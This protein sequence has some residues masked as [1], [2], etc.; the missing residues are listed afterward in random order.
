MDTFS[1]SNRLG[2]EASPYLKR[3]AGQPVH[4]HAWGKEPFQEAGNAGRPLLVSLGY[5]ANQC[6]KADAFF[7]DPAVAEAA[8]TSFVCVKVD[9]FERPEVD[10]FL[11]GLAGAGPDAYPLIAFLTPEGHPYRFRPPVLGDSAADLGGSIEAAARL[12]SESAEE[13]RREASRI[14]EE[15]RRAEGAAPGEGAG[16]SLLQQAVFALQSAFDETNGGFG[17]PP[18]PLRAPAIEFLL[19]AAG[20]GV[21]RAST[22]AE[23]TLR[24]M[25]QGGIFDQVGGGFHHLATDRTWKVPRFEKLLCDN[26]LLAR[27][28]IH[29]WQLLKKDQFSRVALE[30]L[31]YLLRDL[32]DPAGAFYAGQSAGSGQDEGAYYTWT[33]DEFR[34]VAPDAGLKYGVTQKGN[35]RGRNVLTL[36]DEERPGPERAALFKH[37]AERPRPPLDEKI[38]TSWNGLAIGALAEAGAAL[39]RADLVEAARRAAS[40]I[41]LRN[42]HRSTRRLW[43][44]RP[45]E[46]HS[47]PGMLEDYAYLADGL[48]TLWETTFE[49]EWITTC[50]E[51]VRIMLDEFS[52]PTTGGLVSTTPS[53]DP[54]VPRAAAV[55]DG[56]GPSPASVASILLG[57]LAVLTGNQGYA[58]KAASVVGAGAPAL[59]E[60]HLDGAGML[61]AVDAF[62]T[63][64]TE[65]V[66]LGS[67]GDRRTR[68]L[69]RQVWIRYLPNKVVA[70]APPLI[71]FPLLE[72]KEPVGDAPTAHISHGGTRKAPVTEPE[73]FETALKF[74]T[75]PTERQVGRVT[76]LIDNA[77][78]RRHFFD[79]LQNPAWI[80]PLKDAGIFDEPPAP[81]Y[82]LAEGTVGSP[83]WPESKYLARMAVYD[84][85]TV[86]H[87]AMAVPDADNVQVHEDLADVAL[88]LPADMAARFVP[89]AREWLK[90]PYL[91]HLPEKLANLMVRLA[92]G[93]QAQAAIELA[94]ALYEL[95]P[96]DPSES[97]QPVW[98]PA[99]PR[100]K[101][102]RFAYETLATEQLP[103]VA[104]KAPLPAMELV[105]DLLTSAIEL[106]HRPGEADPPN[107]FSHLWRPAMYEH[108]QNADKTLREPLVKALVTI[109]ENIAR[110]QPSLVL[111]IVRRLERRPW[112]IFRRVA[113][114][115]L[116][117]WPEISPESI[118]RR[119]T[120]RHLFR[121]PHFHHEYLLLARDHFE[122]LSPEDQAV[123]LQWIDEGPDLA[124]WSSDPATLDLD[125]PEKKQEY[126]DRW[127]LNRLDMLHESLPPA[128]LTRFEE[129][130]ERFGPPEHPDLVVYFPG[131]RTDPTTPR[132]ADDLHEAELGELVGFLAEWKPAPGLGNPTVEGLARKLAAV[133]AGEPRKFAEAARRFK[134][135]DPAYV[136]A[137]LLGL[138]E[139][140]E[141][142]EFPWRA[143]LDLA[144]WAAEVKPG[145]QADR[146]RPARIEIARLLSRGLQPPAAE[147]PD[148][149]KQK[150][151]Q[152]PFRFRK[153]VWRA[154]APLTNDADPD[155]APAAA[156]G[157]VATAIADSNA[158][159]RGEAMHAVCRYALWLRR[160][161]ETSSNARERLP[162]GFDEMPEVR[163]VLDAHLDPAA[164]PAPAIR[165]VYGRWFSYLL[166]LD[167]RW[168][169]ANVERIFP[170]EPGLEHL[171]DAAWEGHIG[172]SSPYDHLLGVIEAEYERA[173]DRVAGYEPPPPGA[174]S[175]LHRLAEHLTVFYLRGKIGLE[176]SGMLARFFADAPDALRQHAVAFIGRSLKN[177]EGRVPADIA[178]RMQALW[179]KRMQAAEQS[180]DV[181]G[182]AG[183]LSSFG[184]WF[185]SR[186]LDVS[187]SIRQLLK[188]LDH[189]IKV[190]PANMVITALKEMDESLVNRKVEALSKILA[191]EQ[192]SVN[193]VAWTEDSRQI[194]YQALNSRDDQA[195]TTALSLLSFFD[196]KQLEELV[197]WD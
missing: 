149:E 145:Q 196:V 81:I 174:V 175:P 96:A 63:K 30:T 51:L 37:R 48:Y 17:D 71:P 156:P 1:S 86:Q 180:G 173:V 64:P 143:L 181:K 83:P 41:L 120:D 22:V 127:R 110:E 187:W 20:R 148:Q 59:Q 39:D 195:R 113:L 61:C 43:H 161:I 171:R 76:E 191:M 53:H 45:D 126:A 138:R 69:R 98:M 119:L 122:E 164:D 159:V 58:R 38:L 162:R 15:R 153:E 154:I 23:T 103:Q 170:K 65:I 152:I 19:R 137:V 114:H 179:D 66:V 131:T 18:R 100:A 79:N 160:E 87:V 7:D 28:Y 11:A 97:K 144:G 10:A 157:R 26:A 50:E 167:P 130:V 36:A 141:G 134:E 192:D 101:F 163:E 108:D 67:A 8:N 117:V 178:M 177:Q 118:Y 102:S 68:E 47:V 129:L 147:K 188:V 142:F 194:I 111:E 146:W 139:A 80:P 42:R 182:F 34:K 74:W 91:L 166:L 92:Q 94:E 77:L 72:G 6:L 112:H 165:S 176:R 125:T 95:R 55:H 78:H 32:A 13:A 84:P 124:L 52:D 16:T 168:G 60:R 128:A 104:D 106:S 56:I 2:T 14:V 88:A 99:E 27:C 193:L 33:Y 136:W 89:K 29:A 90:S 73:E 49:P 12:W 82:D 190:E 121:D 155:I 189:G 169:S 116:R 35:F 172:F 5:L 4:W 185:A 109:V 85:E 184:W 57:K 158:T 123:I 133:V 107:D 105:A 24:K 93:N 132:Q 186:K 140:A 25:A 62:V 21:A 31:E 151:A 44:Y 150:R 54:F 70:G 115:L 40:T 3:N 197:R 46:K 75:K 135:L 9:I 183:E